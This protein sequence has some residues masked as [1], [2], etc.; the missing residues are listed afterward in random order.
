MQGKQAGQVAHVY[1]AG[2]RMSDP[3]AAAAQAARP[4]RADRPG[5]ERTAWVAPTR[6]RQGDAPDWK[7]ISSLPAVAPMAASPEQLQERKSCRVQQVWQEQREPSSDLSPLSMRKKA[8]RHSR[9]GRR[10][11]PV[12]CAKPV[13]AA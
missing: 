13:A 2:G 3:L 4:V 1:M 8:V 6:K 11:A 12:S 5:V 7:R 9:M 10:S